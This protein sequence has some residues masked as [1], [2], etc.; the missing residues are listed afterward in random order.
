MSVLCIKF[1]LQAFSVVHKWHSLEAMNE[2]DIE[3]VMVYSDNEICWIYSELKEKHELSRHEM[4]V[5][6]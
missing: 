2:K 3:Y 1:S 5:R 4:T 6:E